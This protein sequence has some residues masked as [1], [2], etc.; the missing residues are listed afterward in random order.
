MLGGNA[1]RERLGHSGI[2]LNFILLLALARTLLRRDG[3]G[4]Q[5]YFYHFRLDLVEN[6]TA[7]EVVRSQGLIIQSLLLARL[8]T[9]IVLSLD[10]Y[11]LM[12]LFLFG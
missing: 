9:E 4:S 12:F 7:S 2:H 8:Y 1:F 3:F 6:L 10:N 11:L 5:N